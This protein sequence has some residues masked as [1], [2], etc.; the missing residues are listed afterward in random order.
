M[1]YFNNIP[2]ENIVVGVN[3]V[4]MSIG[5]CMDSSAPNYNEFATF[6]DNSCIEIPEGILGCTDGDALNY[7][8]NATE[9]DGSCI[10]CVYGC[11][12]PNADNYAG[13]G[14]TNGIDPPATCDSEDCIYPE[15]YSVT[16]QNDPN[17]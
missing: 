2:G 14:N 6:D 11:M 7:N 13:P 3:I 9:D 8:E 12:D 16:I 1:P 4:D 15:E 5:G 10:Y 17:D